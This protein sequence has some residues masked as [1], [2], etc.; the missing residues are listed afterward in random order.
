M[1][2]VVP[3]SNTSI[4]MGGGGF[5]EIWTVA[6]TAEICMEGPLQMRDNGWGDGSVVKNKYCSSREPNFSSQCPQL[7]NPQL[8]VVPVSKD[9]MSPLA[10]NGTWI[11]VHVFSL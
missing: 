10:S 4:H 11:H 6:A 1:I 9:L 2:W 7:G 3:K 8:S 5:V